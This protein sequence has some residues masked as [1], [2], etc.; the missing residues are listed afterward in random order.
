M[1]LGR[2]SSDA[3]LVYIRPPV[4]E[5]TNQMSSDMIHFD[6]FLDVTDLRRAQ[7]SDPRTRQGLFN[8]GK[9][10]N[11]PVKMLEMHLHH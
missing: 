6:S 9:L 2:W 1:L 4:L 5:W 8:A 11:H 10:D 7:P 3:F